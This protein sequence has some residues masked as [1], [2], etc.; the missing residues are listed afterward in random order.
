MPTQN[1]SIHGEWSSRLAFILAA[2]GSA[3]GLG[4]IWKFPYMAGEN[5]GGAFVLVYLAFI[6]LF[7]LPI[8]MAEVLLGR[9]GRQ[10]PINTLKSLCQQEQV[11]KLWSVIGWSGMLAGVLILSYYSVIA[12]WSLFYVL[13]SAAGGLLAIQEQAAEDL[14]TNLLS[15]PV[16]LVF[17]HSIFMFMTMVVVARGVSNGLEVAVR[18]LMPMLFVLILIL[19]AYAISQGGFLQGLQFMFTPDFS[20]LNG[21]VLLDAMGQAFFSLSLGMGAIMMYGSY[22]PQTASISRT[23]LAVAIADSSVAI[24]AGLAIFPIVFVN[25]L[26]T[27]QGPGLIFNT[28]PLAFGQMPGGIIFGTLFFLLLVFAAWTS[29]ISLIEPAVAWLVETK[30]QSRLKASIVCGIVTWLIGLGTVLSFNHWDSITLFGKT[31]FDCLDYLTFNIMLPLG[32]LLIALFVGWV[33]REQAVR[34]EI[35]LQQ[36]MVYQVWRVLLKYFTPIGLVVVFL[37]AIGII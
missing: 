6:A 13:E 25:N 37:S 29:S 5:G 30:K 10:S 26:A 28:L 2:A 4:N 12:G 20:K 27:A 14:F 21:D 15:D 9:R 16:T 17:W 1:S 36:E 33:M 3:V 8:M 23:T 31:V 18:F 34:E 32:G 24:L 35:N 7:G 11:S 22:L 19:I